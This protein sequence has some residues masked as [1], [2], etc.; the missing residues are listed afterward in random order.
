[1]SLTCPM[2]GEENSSNAVACKYC[3]ETLFGG[4]GA[5]SSAG[6]WR[7][8]K[9]LVMEKNAQL[10]NRCVKSNVTTDGRLRRRLSWHPPALLLVFLLCGPVPYIIV[11]LLTRKQ[12]TIEIGLSEEWFEKRRRATLFGW[13][14]VVFSIVLLF[15][16][17]GATGKGDTG[18]ILIFGAILVGL[19]GAIF[20]LMGSRMVYAKQITGT[21]VFLNGVCQEYMEALPEWR[22]GS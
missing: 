9:T 3:G 10:P 16:G 17:F 7:N 14:A 5:W 8:G 22:G 20:G 4:S 15:V 12:A 19:F 1:M 13:G 18:A 11:A 2:C 6:L 21:H